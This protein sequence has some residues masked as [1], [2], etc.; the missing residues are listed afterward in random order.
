MSGWVRHVWGDNGWTGGQYSVWRALLGL[1]VLG[2]SIRGLFQPD[3]PSS[4]IVLSATALVLGLPVIVGWFDGP[5]SALLA[6][7]TGGLVILDPTL[8]TQLWP[9]VAALVLHAVAPPGPFLSRHA[10]GRTDPD[11]G[12]KLPAWI[13]LGVWLVLL[14]ATVLAVFDEHSTGTSWTC[15]TSRAVVVATTVLAAT[16]KLRR[17]AWLLW[18]LAWG[19]EWFGGSPGWL[20]AGV[21]P[22]WLLAADP[23]WIPPGRH[24]EPNSPVAPPDDVVPAAPADAT[25]WIFYDGTCGLCHG[26]VRLILAE[27]RNPIP[28]RLAPLQGTA[29]RERVDA[30]A[31]A[32]IPDSIVVMPPG[33]EML[34]ESVAAL[35]FTRLLGGGWRGLSCGLT[36][37]PRPLRDLGYRIVAAIRHRVFRRPTGACPLLPTHLRDRFDLRSDE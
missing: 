6:T 18:V 37:V 22:C 34:V 32:A 14:T 26:C 30:S 11:G 1:G 16:P 9:L 8:P 5:A 4:T 29:F 25:T 36:L 21:L 2:L 27:D 15:M 31:R 33:G 20:M 12:W 10:K 7:V 23:A 17:W 24:R 13:H 3:L 19:A 28:V 35:E